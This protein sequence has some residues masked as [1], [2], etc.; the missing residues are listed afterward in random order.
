[1]SIWSISH[2]VGC[3][4]LHISYYRFSSLAWKTLKVNSFLCKIFDNIKQFWWG[5]PARTN[6][7]LGLIP[8][9]MVDRNEAQEMFHFQ[10]SDILA[11]F[12]QY[13]SYI[14]ESNTCFLGEIP[15]CLIW[16]KI[17]YIYFETLH[18]SEY[19]YLILIYLRFQFQKGQNR[20]LSKNNHHKSISSMSH[21]KQWHKFFWKWVKSVFLWYTYL[22]L[23]ISNA[24]EIFSCQFIY[25]LSTKCPFFSLILVDNQ[26]TPW[27]P[28]GAEDILFL[29][30]TISE[31]E[32]CSTRDTRSLK[33]TLI[34]YYLAKY[35]LAPQQQCQNVKLLN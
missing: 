6:H 33:K 21:Y 3:W 20:I 27:K 17:I 23:C 29:N 8:F 34:T 12:C 25:I 19:K 14:H 28:R 31:P 35:I 16:K 10:K 15:N 18:I 5:C 26:R 2:L 13:Q 32:N 1:M 11:T 7:D 4:I 22:K 30:P 9:Q 24:F